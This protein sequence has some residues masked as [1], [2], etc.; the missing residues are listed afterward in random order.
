MDKISVIVPVYNCQEY[1]EECMR[2][3]MKQKSEEYL[4]EII[5][6]NDGTKDNSEEIILSIKDENC[7][8]IKQENQG[9]SGARNTGL[10]HATGNLIFFLDSDDYMPDDTLK[11]LYKKY[12]ETKDDVIV[13]KVI[14]FNSKGF[15]DYY[16]NKWVTN[17]S[18]FTYKD[19]AKLLDM[20][21]VC[22]KLYKAEV[23]KG[24]E[25]LPR[26]IHED[27]YFSL[28]LMNKEAKYAFLAKPTYYRRIREGDNKSITQGLNL[29]TFRDLLK[30]YYAF[31]SENEVNYYINKSL[32]R[33][34]TRYIARYVSKADVAIANKEQKAF[35]RELDKKTVSLNKVNLLFSRFIWSAETHFYK[36]IKK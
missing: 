22:G 35:W 15:Y 36:M 17:Q 13:G 1:L 2:S 12:I 7:I 28:S 20:I 6:V 19:N 24:L 32:S 8:Y 26:L 29:K 33:K 16:L 30:N 25:F 27:N 14:S 23:I 5:L 31:I 3:A 18:H 34:T 10:K 4:L 11:E 21:S 9:L